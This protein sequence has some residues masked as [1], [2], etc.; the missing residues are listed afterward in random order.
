MHTSITNPEGNTKELTVFMSAF[1]ALHKHYIA[2]H[3]MKMTE[4]GLLTKL[5][6]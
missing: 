5:K 6:H 4:R 1:I 2:K 3:Q